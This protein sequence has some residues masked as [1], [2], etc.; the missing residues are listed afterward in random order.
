MVSLDHLHDLALLYLG[1]AYGADA[2]LAPAEESEIV[3]RLRRW[4]PDRDPALLQH[5][6]REASLTYFGGASRERLEEA[7][8]TLGR[9]L[10]E[11]TRREVAFD[12]FKIARADGQVL[13]AES[14]YVHYIRTAW[15]MEGED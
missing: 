15:G 13:P 12:L 4:Q 2:H 7:I 5:V 6:L 8:R 10:P 3:A 9:H 14:S 11:E 1:L